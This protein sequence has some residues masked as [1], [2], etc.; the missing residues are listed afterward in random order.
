MQFKSKIDWWILLL[1]L[2]GLAMMPVA[3]VAVMLD[4][5]V[6]DT[7][8]VV[9]SFAVIM[10]MTLMVSVMIRTHYTVQ[11]GQLRI[12]SGPFGWTIPL[13]QITEVTETRNPLSS[14]AMSLDRLKIR[15]GKRKWIMVSPADKAGFLKAIG[16]SL[17]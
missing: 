2:F 14:P 15:Y 16:Q 6:D 3:L 8:R 4:E 13:D 1:L 9:T 7:T 12:V 5:T 11:Y 10:G 17:E